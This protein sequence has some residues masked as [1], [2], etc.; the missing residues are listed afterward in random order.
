[1]YL[2]ANTISDPEIETQGGLA[3]TGRIYDKFYAQI[4]NQIIVFFNEYVA[5]QS[6]LEIT[7]IS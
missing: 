6:T 5:A 4:Y 2:I 3:E 7:P 1:M